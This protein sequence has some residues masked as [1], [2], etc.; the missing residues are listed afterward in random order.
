MCCR[1][2]NLTCM[3]QCAGLSASLPLAPMRAFADV[4]LGEVDL[5]DEKFAY[6]LTYPAGWTPASKPVKTH[7]SE[8]LIKSPVKGVSL[9][10]SIDPVKIETLE[11]FGTAEQAS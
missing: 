7:L 8:L 10:V 6:R 9:G 11:Q 3:A 5:N 1:A 2:Y 4:A